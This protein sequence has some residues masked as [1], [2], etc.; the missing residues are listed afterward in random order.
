MTYEE[1]QLAHANVITGRHMEVI[2]NGGMRA[3]CTALDRKKAEM[4]DPKLLLGESINS[5]SID[6]GVEYEQEA[7]DHYELIYDVDVERDPYDLIVHPEIEYLACTPDFKYVGKERIVGEVKCPYNR[8]VH[9]MNVIH[10]S[11]IESYKPQIMLE[12]ACFKADWAHFISYDPRHPDP[13]MQF[14]RIIA[15]PD[16]DYI[17][18]MLNRCH[19]F[20]HYLTTDTRPSMNQFCDDIP[21]LF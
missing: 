10:A 11:G 2:M 8:D 6:H 17:D 18:K 16:P 14:I 15:E 1:W 5:R 19:E 9:M 7:I 13:A 20:W 12:V 21:D 3:W 4:E